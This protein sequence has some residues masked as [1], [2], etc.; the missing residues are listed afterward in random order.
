MQEGVRKK[1]SGRLS[2][3]SYII[4]MYSEC[5]WAAKETLFAAPVQALSRGKIRTDAA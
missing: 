2:H 4:I 1:K 3:F 5:F